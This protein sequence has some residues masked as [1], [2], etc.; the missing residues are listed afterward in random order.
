MCF[1]ALFVAVRTTSDHENE[2]VL[3]AMSVLHVHFLRYLVN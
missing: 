1:S 2:I 3:N